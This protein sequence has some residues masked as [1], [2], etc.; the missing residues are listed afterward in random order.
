MEIY[1]IT[2]KDNVIRDISS[3]KGNLSI[4]NAYDNAQIS[5]IDQL[6][7]GIGVGDIYN[8]KDRTFTQST[9]QKT[10]RET[11]SRR[12]LKIHAKIRQM[13][14]DALI[15]EGDKDFT[16]IKQGLVGG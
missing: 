9:E 11:E 8:S 10:S 7:S 15:A 1:I 13:A 4:G 2:D 3:L 12:E 5:A 6:P 14:I 16:I